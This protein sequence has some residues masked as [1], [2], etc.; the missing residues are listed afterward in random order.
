MGVKESTTP[1][2]SGVQV[3]ESGGGEPAVV[4]LPGLDLEEAE[5]VVGQLAQERR[6]L[7]LEHPGFAEAPPVP[8]VE[9]VRDVA[10]LYL[11]WLDEWTTPWHTAAIVVGAAVL[12]VILASP[13]VTWL[14]RWLV[15]P[16]LAGLLVRRDVDRVPVP[17]PRQ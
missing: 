17:E 6:V 5:P 7:A 8:G 1:G 9:A 10:A 11:G 14:T 12:A 2:T 13:P 3:T 16:P 15:E 4:F